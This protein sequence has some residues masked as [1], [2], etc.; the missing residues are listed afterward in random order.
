[1]KRPPP[2]SLVC[3]RNL[4]SKIL[5]SNQKLAISPDFFEDIYY[6]FLHIVKL[7]KENSNNFFFESDT[8]SISIAFW[9]RTNWTAHFI[10]PSA[11]MESSKSLPIHHQG[12]FVQPKMIYHQP[13]DGHVKTNMGW[14]HTILTLKAFLRSLTHSHQQYQIS[15]AKGYSECP[16]ICHFYKC[17]VKQVTI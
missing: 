11:L 3:P 6:C 1:M 10:S 5:N 14:P 2:G 17:T 12:K 16:M 9:Q 7:P 15:D 13:V 4:T 8:R